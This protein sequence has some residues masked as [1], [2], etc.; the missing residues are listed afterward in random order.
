MPLRLS[1]CRPWWNQRVIVGSQV[2]VLLLAHWAR[3]RRGRCQA[4]G[5]AAAGG[6]REDAREAV[7]GVAEAHEDVVRVGL[8]WCSC[9][10]S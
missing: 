9:V 6:G 7:R 2:A 5:H 1:C 8:R 3:G 4:H 10:C